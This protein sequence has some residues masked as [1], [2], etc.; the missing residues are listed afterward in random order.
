M[1]FDLTGIYHY[2][3]DKQKLSPFFKRRIDHHTFEKMM[4]NGIIYMY[5]ES[6]SVEEFKY[7]L[8]KATLENYIHY[9]Y[10][11][12]IEDL[13]HDDV[14]N[15]IDYMIDT[16]DSVLKMYYYNER[17]NRGDINE[18]YSPAGKEITPNKIVIHKS[19]PMF[20]DKIMEQGLKVRAGECYK[21]YVG[22]GEK[23]IPAIFATNSTNKR[24]SFDST[25]D[26]DVWEIDTEMIPDVKW[27]KDKHYE[28]RSKHIV[29]FE[30]IPANAIT[31][32]HEGTGKDWGLME[33]DKDK[34]SKETMMDT[35]QDI[36]DETLE[37]IKHIC[38]ELDSDTFPDWLSF[39]ACDVVDT[40]DK[41][42]LVSIERRKGISTIPMFEVD[43]NLTFN[44]ISSWIDY[45]DFIHLIADRIINKWRIHLIFNIIEQVNSNKREMWEYARTL[46]NARTQGSKL[47]FSKSAV[48]ANPMRFRPY[49]R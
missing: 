38:E 29:T 35:F 16:Y 5:F 31:L 47:R 25:Y 36:V 24:A 26:D 13:P 30:N 32:K 9:K 45:D 10:N 28:S 37:E 4:K 17:K 2:M 11:I 14:Y 41:I 20:R 19:N 22:Y 40:I 15:F 12:D 34:L 42:S 46:K 3:S 48:K 1:F 18:N 6:K 21:T 8:V 43:V 33:S 49:N 7:K 39:D 23:C 27:Y 44:S